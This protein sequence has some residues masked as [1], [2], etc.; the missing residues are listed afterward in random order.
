VEKGETPPQEEEAPEREEEEGQEVT[1]LKHTAGR[2]I[3]QH[4]LRE[5]GGG[6]G[7]DRETLR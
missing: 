1:H 6:A 3:P 2:E 7:G 5:G 4:F